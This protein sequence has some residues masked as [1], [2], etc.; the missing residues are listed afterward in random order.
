MASSAAQSANTVVAGFEA[1]GWL[2]EPG[3]K[4][5]GEVT[6]LSAGYSDYRAKT[7]NGNGTYPIITVKVTEPSQSA[8]K[9]VTAGTE[10][11]VHGF[12]HILY[13]RF[14]SLRP[15]L[16]EVVE[17]EC[18][19]KRPTRDGSQSVVLYK[20]RVRGREGTSGWDDLFGP[21]PGRHG[22]PPAGVDPMTGELAA[23]HPF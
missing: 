3:D 1:A 21:P 20:C 2:P 12:Q 7:N 9:A 4:L 22:A 11:S 10:I 19:G 8:G 16:G 17:I 6:E 18:G 14:M 5:I 15:A 13:D 23:D